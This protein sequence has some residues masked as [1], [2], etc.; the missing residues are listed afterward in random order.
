ME[1]CTECKNELKLSSER[2]GDKEAVYMLHGPR[3]CVKYLKLYAENIDTVLTD[4][5]IKLKDLRVAIEDEFRFRARVG[6]MDEETWMKRL[7]VKGLQEAIT[8]A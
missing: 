5:E 2:D 7:C 3:E 1:L 8:K 6:R 4:T